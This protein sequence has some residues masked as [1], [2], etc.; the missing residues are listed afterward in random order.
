MKLNGQVLKYKNSFFCEVTVDDTEN[1]IS[2]EELKEKREISFTKGEI[3]HVLSVEDLQIWVFVCTTQKCSHNY[4][5]SEIC[6][7]VYL[8]PNF[9]FNNLSAIISSNEKTNLKKKSFI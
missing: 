4:L 9:S 6:N 7:I 5:T 3:E 2:L 8:N 1:L